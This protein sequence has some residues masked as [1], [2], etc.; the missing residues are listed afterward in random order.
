M[1]LYI[2]GFASCGNGNKSSIL[3]QFFGED[4]V[5]S[6]DL[7]P[8]PKEAI[9]FLSNLIE[10]HSVKMLVG[11]SL[12][13]YY[14]IHLA[15]K[16]DLKAVLINPALRPF[17]SLNALVGKIRRYCDGFE[18]EWK[19]EY[20]RQLIDLFTPKVEFSRYLVLL[21]TGDE[22]LNYEEAVNRFRCSKVVVEY[23]GNHRF[24]NLDDYLYMIK[25][26]YER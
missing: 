18:F 12:G 7:P 24:E 3:K 15:E 5:L 1:I 17:E 14:S 9:K 11:S 21:Q 2:H 26:F 13:G 10:K 23:G 4:K 20:I 22:L 6:P 19:R 16:H 8:E 25:N